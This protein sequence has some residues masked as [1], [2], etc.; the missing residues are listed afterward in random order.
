MS[1]RYDALLSTLRATSDDDLTAG[2]PASA[3]AIARAERDLGVTFPPQY[4]R[5]LAT[6]GEL[7][8][9][10]REVFGIHASEPGQVVTQSLLYRGEEGVPDRAVV[11]EIDGVEGAPIGFVPGADAAVEPPVHRWEPERAV[12]IAA[13]FA[14][15]LANVAGGIVARAPESPPGRIFDPPW[16]QMRSGGGVS[17]DRKEVKVAYTI[18]QRIKYDGVS[19][20][21]LVRELN[22]RRVPARTLAEWSVDAAREAYD[23]WKDR[24]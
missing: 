3:D 22:T 14:D 8:V 19:F 1:D 16:G 18:V 21:M 24:Y 7:A 2:Q 23:A 9:A 5:F 12:P 10:P 11:V 15:Y 17:A 13:D 6:F 20:A 4:R